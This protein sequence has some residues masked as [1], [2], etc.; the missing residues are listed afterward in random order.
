MIQNSMAIKENE[1]T[2]RDKLHLLKAVAVLS[3]LG[4]KGGII[5]EIQTRS[6]MET[7]KAL[8]GFADSLVKVRNRFSEE[9]Y[10]YE[11]IQQLLDDLK[12]ETKDVT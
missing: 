4:I 3:K 11:C 6:Q 2:S 8:L 5:D 10:G 7:G 1:F 12:G 9:S